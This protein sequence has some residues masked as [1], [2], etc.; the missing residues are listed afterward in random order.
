MSDSSAVIRHI[1]SNCIHKICS[2]QV[3]SDLASAVK[4]LVENSL[5]A[6]ATVIEIKL[7]DMGLASVEIIDNGNGISVENHA[8]VALKHYTS[9]IAAFDDL[10]N[11]KSF[12]FRGEALNALCELCESLVLSTR[13]ANDSLGTRLSFQRDGRYRTYT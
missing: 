13:T 5:D 4:E 3:I 6:E 1:D 10:E 12:G 2:G 11:I 7:K 9:K 8:S